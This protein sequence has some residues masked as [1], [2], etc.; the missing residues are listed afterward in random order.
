MIH[1]EF[2]S[3]FLFQIILPICCPGFLTDGECILPY[4]KHKKTSALDMTR[5]LPSLTESYNQ[6]DKDDLV[7]KRTSRFNPI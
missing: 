2:S 7:R 1:T 5:T 6:F 4:P 3:I